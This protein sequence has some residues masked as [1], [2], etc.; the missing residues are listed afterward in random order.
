[1]GSPAL[2]AAVPYS[3]NEVLQQ[4]T[5]IIKNNKQLSVLTLQYCRDL[6]MSVTKTNANRQNSVQALITQ[7]LK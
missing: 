6:E 5:K 4:I 1:M 3:V 7:C 2:A